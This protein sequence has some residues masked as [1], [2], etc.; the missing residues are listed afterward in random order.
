MKKA[1]VYL[2]ALLIGLSGTASPAY[3]FYLDPVE[4]TP[5]ID[6]VLYYED[7]VGNIEGEVVTYCN[8]NVVHLGG[9]GT[10]SWTDYCGCG[11]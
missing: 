5:Y 11:G 2:L 9:F 1:A 4:C 7:Y 6:T 8:G 3:A 10:H